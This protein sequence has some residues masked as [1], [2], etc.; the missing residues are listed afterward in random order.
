MYSPR[1]LNEIGLSR[2]SAS[3]FGGGGVGRNDVALISNGVAVS[4]EPQQQAS[5]DIFTLTDD[6][7]TSSASLIPLERPTAPVVVILADHQRLFACLQPISRMP[8]AMSCEQT[9]VIKDE[10]KTNK[11]TSRNRMA[12]SHGWPS[13]P[14]SHSRRN[15]NARQINEHSR[16]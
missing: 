8:L 2:N 13:L 6:F 3:A 5:I 10:V 9:G 1:R 12:L 16:Q 4:G 14:R 7:A 11:A 15:G